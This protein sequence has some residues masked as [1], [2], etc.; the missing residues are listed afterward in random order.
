LPGV[1]G[2]NPTPLRS[3]RSCWFRKKRVGETEFVISKFTEI[4]NLQFES[5]LNQT[6]AGLVKTG[7]ARLPS[8]FLGW[9]PLC[10][11]S[12]IPGW[13]LQLWHSTW[14]SYLAS[15]ISDFG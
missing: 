6:P 8:R 15:S 1:R 13:K 12:K 11:I 14:G 5:E 9:D 3:W 10:C 2:V 4:F 7:D